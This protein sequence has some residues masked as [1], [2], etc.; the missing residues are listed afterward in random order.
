MESAKESHCSTEHLLGK[1]S[2]FVKNLQKLAFNFSLAKLLL[3]M[4]VY[5]QLIGIKVRNSVLVRTCL[6]ALISMCTCV[7]SKSTRTC[8]S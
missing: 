5:V 6:L 2:W 7:N 8:I 3:V 4:V 1:L